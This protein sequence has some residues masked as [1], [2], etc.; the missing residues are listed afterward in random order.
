LADYRA[1]ATTRHLADC[2][3]IGKTTVTKLLREH[4]LPLRHQGLTAEQVAQAVQFYEAGKS[5]AQTAR[6]LGLPINSVYDAL[7]RAGTAMR[8]PHEH[9]SR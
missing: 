3:G 6:Q 4:H 8:S 1:S 2:Y 9:V 5:V 7:K